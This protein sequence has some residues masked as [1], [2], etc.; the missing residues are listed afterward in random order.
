MKYLVQVW[1]KDPVGRGNHAYVFD[2]RDH[3]HMKSY[4]DVNTTILVAKNKTL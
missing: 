3:S 1:T 2:F 4:E